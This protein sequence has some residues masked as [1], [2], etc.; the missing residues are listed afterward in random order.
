MTRNQIINTVIGRLIKQ[1][2]YGTQELH[3]VNSPAY[4]CRDG[5]R[6]AIG[7]LID[8]KTA[9]DFDRLG[10]IE[11]IFDDTRGSIPP[12]LVGHMDLLSELQRAHD[13]SCGRAWKTGI[14]FHEFIM[15]I[16]EL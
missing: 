10:T 2:G 8:D 12:E 6:C 9:R 5:K 15:E 4:L 7:V 3:G 13:T 16:S 11:E 14:P 1:G